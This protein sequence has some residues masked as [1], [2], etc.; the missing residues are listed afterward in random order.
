MR[1]PLAVLTMCASAAILAVP[2]V[3]QVCTI[4]VTIAAGQSESSVLQPSSVSLTDCGGRSVPG[5][6]APIA[7]I[8][9]AAVDATTD[10]VRVLLCT[11]SAGSRCLALGDSY[12]AVDEL[13]MAQSPAGVPTQSI[14]IDPYIGATWAYW[15]LQLVDAANAAD[16]QTADRVF[17]VYVRPI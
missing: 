16:A 1:N 7:I 11:S 17:T 10:A 14:R 5:T 2:A 9:P 8:P 6:L 12:K 15:R 3:S 13:G 4:S